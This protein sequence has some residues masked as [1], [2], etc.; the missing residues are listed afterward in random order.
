MQRRNSE[1]IASAISRFLREEGLETPY[2][3]YKLMKSLEDVLGEGISRYVGNTY[4]KNQTLYVEMK[5]SV[6]RQEL[7]VGRQNLVRKLNEAVGSFTI[8]D[9]SFY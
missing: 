4:I 5:S 7:N 3:Q 6:L 1:H 2:N 8:A 9:I